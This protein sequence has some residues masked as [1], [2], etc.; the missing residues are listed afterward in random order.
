MGMVPRQLG[1]G[2]Y[3]TTFLNLKNEPVLKQA[4]TLETFQTC[5]VEAKVMM[6]LTK[7]DSFQCLVGMCPDRM[8]LVTRYTGQTLTRGLVSG[9]ASGHKTTSART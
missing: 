8:C 1:K 3:G 6:L 9:R 5:I 4:Q 7:Y 2:S